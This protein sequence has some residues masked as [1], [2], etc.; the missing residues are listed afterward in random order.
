MLRIL[1][2]VL[3]VVLCGSSLLA[4]DAKPGRIGAYVTFTAAELSSP[5]LLQKSMK[6]F[7]S[8]GV[9]FILPFMAKHTRGTVNWDSKVAP[10]ELIGDRTMMEK[11][12]KAARA[13]GLK[14]HPVIGVVT[15]GSESGPNV[16]LQRN[17]S[18]AWHYDGKAQGYIDPGNAEARAYQIALITELITKYEVD[19]LSLDYMRCPNRVG[20]TETGRKHFLKESG[21]DLA[22]LV[23]LSPGIDLDTEGGRKANREMKSSARNHPVWPEWHRWRTEAINNFVQEIQTAVHKVKPGLPIS[24]YVWGARTYTGNYET[25]QDWTTWIKNGWL[26]WINPSGYRYTEEEF[27]ETVKANRDLIPKGFPYY[28]TIGVT[29]SHGKLQN[30][31]ELIQQLRIAA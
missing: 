30:S 11:V 12:L 2:C 20:Y 16:L 14:V 8:S 24:S 1:I 29:T 5:E 21:V 13:E 15:E 25:C 22:K 6:E 19:G 3:A 9:D 7:K 23:E 17:P 31:G 10:S 28:I 18:W 4:T 26:D 27:R